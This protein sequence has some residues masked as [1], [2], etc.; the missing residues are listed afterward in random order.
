MKIIFDTGKDIITFNVDGITVNIISSSGTTDFIANPKTFEDQA[1]QKRNLMLLR[2]KK[3]EKF[4]LMWKEDLEKFSKFTTE[5]EIVEDIMDDFHKKRGW[6][7]IK[8]GI[9]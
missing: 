4:Y 2:R 6:R 8:N 3:G 7:L 9:N 5:D 1:K